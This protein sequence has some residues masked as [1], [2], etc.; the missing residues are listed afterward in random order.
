MPKI[1]ESKIADILN[2]LL[3]ENIKTGESL[4]SK[5]DK[6]V[7]NLTIVVKA[8]D[9]SVATRTSEIQEL[10]KALNNAPKVSKA[11]KY[12]TIFICVLTG[13]IIS[14]LFFSYSTSVITYNYVKTH[15][16]YQELTQKYDELENYAILLK[17]KNE[18]LE[19]TLGLTLT[20]NGREK[21]NEL[22]SEE[23]QKIE[24]E[25]H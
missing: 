6:S 10:V 24:K 3:T 20:P 13:I 17:N 25:Q 22:F 19:R 12:Q 8:L 1:D 9:G 7:G 4:I 11:I 5:M 18:A 2:S 15:N 23:L 16:T 21:F 14:A